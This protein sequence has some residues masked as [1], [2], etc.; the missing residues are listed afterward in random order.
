[1]FGVERMAKLAHALEDLLDAVRM[2]RRPLDLPTF[3]LLNQATEL[4]GKC[5]AEE[6]AG[7]P[8]HTGEAC[9]RLAQALRSRPA[10][11]AAAGGDPI[12]AFALDPAVLG[13]LTEY[14]EHRLRFNLGKGQSLFR[15]RVSFDLATFDTALD[16]LKVKLKELGEVVS[17]LPSSDASDPNAIA[18]ELPPSLPPSLP[19]LAR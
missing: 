14:E 6:A 11:A 12:D 4:L 18:F 15:V 1:M 17:T 19:P 8:A 2:G 7:K 3:K 13:V 10:L 9:E 16:A 5:I